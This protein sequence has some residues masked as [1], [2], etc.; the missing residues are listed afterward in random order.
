MIS[1]L[2][3]SLLLELFS[4]DWEVW[5]ELCRVYW[6]RCPRSATDGNL[7]AG[8][9]VM[10]CVGVFLKSSNDCHTSRPECIAFRSSCFTVP[11]VFFFRLSIRLRVAWTGSHVFELP[12]LR[13]SMK[14][15]RAKLGIVVRP[16]SFWCTISGK[17][18]LRFQ[19]SNDCKGSRRTELICLC[20]IAVTVDNHQVVFSLQFK[21]ITCNFL[22]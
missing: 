3:L 9:T 5:L 12:F 2:P 19:F 17:M 15:F 6:E 4:I 22:P 8:L 20:K 13:K 10:P 11:T 14:F 1:S 16:Y 7:C 18:L 21:Q